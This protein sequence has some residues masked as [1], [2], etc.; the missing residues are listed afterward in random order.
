MAKRKTTAFYRRE[1]EKH[2]G[3]LNWKKAVENLEKAIKNYPEH[4]GGAL[5]DADIKSLKENLK[6][7]RYMLKHLRERG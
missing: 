5:A 1:A 7:D 6:A 3:G 4:I 2:E